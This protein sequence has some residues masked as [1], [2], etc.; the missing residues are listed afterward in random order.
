MLQRVCDHFETSLFELH[1]QTKTIRNDETSRKK[2]TGK[3]GDNSK[4]MSCHP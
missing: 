3:V 1:I 4:G 2:K